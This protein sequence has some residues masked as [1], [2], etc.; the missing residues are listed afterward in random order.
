MIVDELP[1]DPIK[2]RRIAGAG[3]DEENGK[4]S[5]CMSNGVSGRLFHYFQKTLKAA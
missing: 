4:G 3:N 1:I 2:T 5:I